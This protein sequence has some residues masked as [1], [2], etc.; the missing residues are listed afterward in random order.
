MDVITYR[1]LI[2][3][4]LIH[5]VMI[6]L[7]DIVTAYLYGTL[8]T[9]IYMLAPPELIKRVQFH[10]KGE[11]TQKLT[12]DLQSGIQQIINS[13]PTAHLLSITNK[14]SSWP[15]ASMDKT[16]P[17]PTEQY[18]ARPNGPSVRPMLHTLSAVGALMYLANQTRPDIS[19]AV[20]LFC[21]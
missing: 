13:G 1:Y 4:A 3:F 18:Q 7:M 17:A 2:A 14:S 21:N 8:D 15:V 19:F 16:Q 11:K 6:H 20:N 5:K 9:E 10:I 12:A